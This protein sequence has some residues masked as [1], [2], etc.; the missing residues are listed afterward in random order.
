MNTKV[1][2]L[3]AGCSRP[4]GYPLANQMKDHLKD[5]AKQIE[6]SAPKLHTITQNALCLFDKLAAQG[7]HAETI[8]DV[9]WFVHQGK[10]P[11]KQ[12]TFQDEHG[13]RLVDE[14]KTAVSA[15]FIAK[16]SEPMAKTLQGY[17]NFLR[18]IFPS[19]THYDR[20]LAGS[21]WRVLSFNYDR[22]FELAFRQHFNVDMTQT[23]YGPTVLNSGLFLV[24]SENV[25]VDTSRFSLLK[26]HGSAGFY[27]M[28]EYGQCNHYHIIPDPIKSVPITD[29]EFIFNGRQGIYSNRPKPSLIV[30]P[31]EKDHLKDYPNN[32]FSFRR[33]IPEIWRAAHE[34]V[35]NADEVWII[36][37]S[38]AEA[39]W[40]HFESLLKCARE[41]CRIFVQNPAAD[42][43][44]A[45]LRVRLPAFEG[46][47]TAS[48][49]TFE[50]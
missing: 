42:G 18:R 33:Y 22:L 47:I 10:I 50:G 25:E 6:H 36:G 23:F 44:A 38:A 13:D 27:S 24:D 20:A 16:E 12:G 41:T 34:F 26:L 11:A 43:I 46:R 39:D 49:T 35:A 48:P 40:F 9:A 21:Q 32:K 5:F 31:H 1:A 37:Y 15:M 29:D 30:F 2:I 28:E 4:Y 7:C 45:K 17:R 19:T 14:A 8:D 3:G